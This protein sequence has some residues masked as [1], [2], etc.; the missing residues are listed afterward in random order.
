VA[1]GLKDFWPQF[2]RRGSYQ[3]PVFATAGSIHA[4]WINRQTSERNA[5]NTQP[6]DADCIDDP[7]SMLS[8][9]HVRSHATASLSSDIGAAAVAP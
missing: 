5:Q 4:G 7:L 6:H 1:G 9:Q 8:G 2:V 3:L